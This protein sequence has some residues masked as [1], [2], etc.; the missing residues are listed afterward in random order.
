MGD[1]TFIIQI[2]KHRS[3]FLYVL[4]RQFSRLR[5]DGYIE[6]RGHITTMHA[7]N[8][9]DGSKKK[10]PIK[11]PSCIDSYGMGATP[12]NDQYERSGFPNVNVR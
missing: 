9:F 4:R 3:L 12:W 6:N 11:S 10:L 5:C 8:C 2:L 7:G 1:G